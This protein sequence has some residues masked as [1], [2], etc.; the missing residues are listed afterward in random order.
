MNERTRPS[1]C[2]STP[3]E[4]LPLLPLE[5]DQA[6]AAFKALADPTR[7]EILALIAAQ[8]EPLC[9]CDVVDR[10]DLTQ[11]TISHHM[12]VLAAAGLVSV[13]RRGIWAYYEIRPDTVAALQDL[14]ARF[15]ARVPALSLR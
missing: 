7:L 1:G 6:V 4:P 8:A 14:L 3:N 5:R 15:N 11:P 9:A 12:K 13:S 10:F 2:C